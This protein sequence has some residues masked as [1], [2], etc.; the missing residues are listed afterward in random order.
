MRFINIMRR[1][2]IAAL[3][4]LIIVIIEAAYYGTRLKNNYHINDTDY[5]ITAP[6]FVYFSYISSPTNIAFLIIIFIISFMVVSN[7]IS[8]KKDHKAAQIKRVRK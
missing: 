2:A 3:I 6:F 5:S 7:M 1:F 4:L 8:K